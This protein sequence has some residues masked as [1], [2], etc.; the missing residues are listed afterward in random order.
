MNDRIHLIFSLSLSLSGGCHRV[1]KWLRTVVFITRL[2]K[3]HQSLLGA[4]ASY[5]QR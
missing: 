5:R 3:S 4:Q 2:I 1:L